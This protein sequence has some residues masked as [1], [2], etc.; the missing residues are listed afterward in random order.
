MQR[1]AITIVRHFAVSHHQV[2]ILVDARRSAEHLGDVFAGAIKRDIS[3]SA[4]AK[5]S[6]IGQAE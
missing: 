3:A 5:M 6:A 4:W 1:A 2:A